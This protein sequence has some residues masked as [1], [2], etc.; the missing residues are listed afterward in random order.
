[1]WIKILRK[2]ELKETFELLTLC[3]SAVCLCKH[4]K[5]V[6]SSSAGLQNRLRS[7]EDIMKR[8]EEMLRSRFRDTHSALLWLRENRHL[9]E[10]NVYEPMMLVVSVLLLYVCVLSPVCFICLIYPATD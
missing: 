5:N 10:G 3:L 4:F 9:F 7:L 1:M 6:F 8:K 2:V